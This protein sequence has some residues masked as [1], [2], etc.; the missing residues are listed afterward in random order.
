MNIDKITIIPL[1]P[2]PV[3]TYDI[4]VDEG[5]RLFLLNQYPDN[6]KDNAGNS[7]SKDANI[8]KNK[9][10]KLLQKKLLFCVNDAFHRI[11]TPRYKCK[12]YITQ[13]WLNFTSKDQHHHQHTHTNSILSAVLYLRVA[14]N[15]CIV[16]HH[17]PHH[18]IFDIISNQ[19]DMFNSKVWKLPIKE[20]LLLIF[21]STLPHSV[22]RVEH[23]TLRVSLSFNTFIKGELGE[24]ISNNHLVL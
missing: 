1:F 24:S 9:E 5:E 22:P 7:T 4:D 21:P 6:V 8:L 18:H 15:D 14:E 20:N 3:F 10:V 19:Y 2:T 12:L 16:L 11:Y 17:P 23:D 13:S